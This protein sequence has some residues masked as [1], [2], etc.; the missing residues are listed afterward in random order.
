MAA[1]SSTL[2]CEIPWTEE[3]VG[4]LRAR[5]DWAHA[6]AKVTL[7]DQRKDFVGMIQLKISDEEMILV[8]PVWPQESLYKAAKVRKS[9]RREADYRDWSDLGRPKPRLLSQNTRDLKDI[10]L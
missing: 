3:S 5:R 10:H 1:H 4:L 8:D 6:Y 9:E 7:S 2:A